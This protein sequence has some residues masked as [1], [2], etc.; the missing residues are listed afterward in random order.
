MSLIK[1]RA[2]TTDSVFYGPKSKRQK[3][4]SPD[5]Y[6]IVN[7]DDDDYK[8]DNDDYKLGSDDCITVNTGTITSDSDKR[9][10]A[11]NV[12][13]SNATSNKNKSPTR[14]VRSQHLVLKDTISSRLLSKSKNNKEI[15]SVNTVITSEKRARLWKCK[16]MSY[17]FNG[18]ESV[19]WIQVSDERNHNYYTSESPLDSQEDYYQDHFNSDDRT[20]G[21]GGV[22]MEKQTTQYLKTLMQ[23]YCKRVNRAGTIIDTELKG[24]TKLCANKFPLIITS[25]IDNVNIDKKT[26]SGTSQG[27]TFHRHIYHTLICGKE[28]LLEQY[29]QTLLS[30]KHDRNNMGTSTI[31]NMGMQL[32]GDDICTGMFITREEMQMLNAKLVTLKNVIKDKS[33]KP[34]KIKGSSNDI[35]KC[36]EKFNIS[37]VVKL[38]EGSKIFT[39]VQAAKQTLD[40]LGLVPICGELLISYGNYATEIDLIAERRTGHD[41]I[42]RPVNVSFKTG[43]SPSIASEQ[44]LQSS[45]SNFEQSTTRDVRTNYRETNAYDKKLNRIADANDRQVHLQHRMQQLCENFILEKHLG[46]KIMDNYILYLGTTS[47]ASLCKVVF[48]KTIKIIEGI[49]IENDISWNYSSH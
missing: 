1:R 37:R 25:R 49:D 40:N 39:W 28:T 11:T 26:H 36:N 12:R 16:L 20:D 30:Y 33:D 21:R 2:T 38:K 43:Y 42:G 14:I 29:R 4:P 48:H 8:L 24:I 35:C 7:I 34:K 46:I 41:E 13:A 15:G 22:E 32:V 5:M 6:E 44:H 47:D 45:F 10:S 23:T 19:E 18:T 27:S 9:K 31:S 17:L 3:Y